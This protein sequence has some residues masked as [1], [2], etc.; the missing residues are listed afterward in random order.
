VSERDGGRS[1]GGLHEATREVLEHSDESARA[2][3]R[4]AWLIGAVGAVFRARVRA[5][6]TQEEVAKRMRTTQSAVARL[7]RDRGG[8]I[9]LHRFVDYALACGVLPDEVTVKPFEEARQAALEADR[10]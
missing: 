1:G 10:G 7:E 5:G 4:H 3:L 8:R 9:T 2:Y 6:L